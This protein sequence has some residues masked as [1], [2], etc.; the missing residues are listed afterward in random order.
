MQD[1][2]V[3]LVGGHSLD[4]LVLQARAMVG[5]KCDVLV[6]LGHALPAAYLAQRLLGTWAG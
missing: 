3:L 2:R 4:D 5:H 6:L 1:T